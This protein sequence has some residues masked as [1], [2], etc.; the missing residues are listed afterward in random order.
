VVALRSSRAEEMEVW[1]CG[2]SRGLAGDFCKG[3]RAF[4]WSEIV[5]PQFREDEIKASIHV[6][7]MLKSHV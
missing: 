6:P 4:G 1:Q 5:T 2:E 3:E 7:R